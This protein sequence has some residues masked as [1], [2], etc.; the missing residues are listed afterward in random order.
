MFYPMATGDSGDSGDNGDR[1]QRFGWRLHPVA[2][3]DSGDNGD[4]GDSGDSPANNTPRCGTM[5][6]N[7][8][9]HRL[10]PDGETPDTP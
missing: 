8:P 10:I 3:G 2:T 6:T 4:S 1:F 7:T 5:A 9:S